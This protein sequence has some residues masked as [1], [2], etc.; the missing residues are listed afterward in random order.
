MNF[1]R[2]SIV[3]ALG[4]SGA[5]GAGVASAQAEVDALVKAARSE[6]PVTMYA[7]VTD[8]VVR[9]VAEA[10]TAKYGVKVQYTRLAGTAIQHRY[11][12]EAQ[13]G[14]FAADVLF[15]A[16]VVPYSQ[17]AV[18]NGWLEPVSGLPVIKSGQLPARFNMETTAL[19]QIA[20]WGL[21]YHTGKVKGSDVPKDWKDLLHPKWKG[22]ILLPDPRSSE[23]YLDFWALLIDRYGESFAAQLRAQNPRQYSSGVPAMQGL[24]AGEG[25]FELPA[26]PALAQTVIAKG[27]PVALVFPELTTGVEM[28]VML[29]ARS[30]AKA[31]NAARLLANYVLTPEGNKVFNDDPGGITLYDKSGLPKQYESPKPGTVARKDAIAKSLGFQ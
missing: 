8:N 12:T 25:A 16:N 11:S 6:P 22:Q 2:L 14:T 15:G 17:M 3:A 28:M 20:P 5:L 26:V 30:K 18:K 9:R 13:A 10:F 31:P 21:A 7:T 23:S 19:V 24:G 29:T 27:A 4:V 1:K